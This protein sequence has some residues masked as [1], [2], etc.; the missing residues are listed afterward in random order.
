[1]SYVH[2]T[3][4]VYCLLNSLQISYPSYKDLLVHIEG[5]ITQKLWHQLSD[6]LIQLCEKPELQ[7]SLDLI[8]VYNTIVS[9]VEKAFNPMKLMVIISNVIKNYSSIFIFY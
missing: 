8:D 1:M 6:H 7:K 5:D 2:I 9:L 4:A 3:D